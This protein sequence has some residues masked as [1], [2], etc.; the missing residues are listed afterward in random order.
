MEAK[1]T[2]LL[3]KEY[4]FNVGM[5]IATFVMPNIIKDF[6]N[7][8]IDKAFVGLTVSEEYK[9]DDIDGLILI[10]GIKHSDGKCEVTNIKVIR[11]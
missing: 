9:F 7:T 11:E 1:Y 5:R 3:I 4:G 6:Q 8:V 2:E 10:S